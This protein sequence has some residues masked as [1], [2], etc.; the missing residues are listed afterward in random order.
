MFNS[1]SKIFYYWTGVA[2][3]A[4]CLFG[5]QGFRT[6][7]RRYQEKHRLARALLQL[8]QDHDRLSHE[9]D[10]IHQEPTY[11]EYLI[12]KHLGY[13]K[14]GEVEYRLIPSEKPDKK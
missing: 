4:V 13:A 8:R 9:L 14:K 1:R 2:A 6:L 12:R 7:V 10:L 11:T 5:N 3:V